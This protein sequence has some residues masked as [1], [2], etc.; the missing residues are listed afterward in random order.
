MDAELRKASGFA[1]SGRLAEAMQLYR[2]VLA[3]QGDH[4]EATHFLGVCLVR[5]DRR[6]E[7]MPF[8]ER[9]VRLAPQNTLYRQ[10]FGLLLA[11]SGELASAEAQFG[12]IL[13]LEQDNPIAHNY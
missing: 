12:E 4:P 13:R 8:V 7:G 5:S 10:N 3:R 2:E 6:D 1:Q 9:S 11:E